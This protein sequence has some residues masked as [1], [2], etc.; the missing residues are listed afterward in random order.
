MARKKALSSSFH[1][2]LRKHATEK[3]AVT[4]DGVEVMMPRYEAVQRRVMADAALET[5]NAAT[6]QARKYLADRLD[7]VAQDGKG[8]AVVNINVL[9]GTQEEFVRKVVNLSG[10]GEVQPEH[11]LEALDDGEA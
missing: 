8:P 1:E 5:P 7:P 2:A 3:I 11:V 6:V 4:V 10:G 9:P